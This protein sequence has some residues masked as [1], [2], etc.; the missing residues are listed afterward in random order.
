MATEAKKPQILLKGESLLHKPHAIQTASSEVPTK[1][2]SEKVLIKKLSTINKKDQNVKLCEMWHRQ[3]ILY[4]TALL[5]SK[6]LENSNPV[7]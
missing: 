3:K 6:S 5:K 7:D 2:Y 1:S 4:F